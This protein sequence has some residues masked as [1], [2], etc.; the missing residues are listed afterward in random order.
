MLSLLKKYSDDNLFKF[1][2][3]YDPKCR[4]VNDFVIQ[5]VIKESIV[6]SE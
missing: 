6:M 5:R 3:E 1:F 2:K 4:W